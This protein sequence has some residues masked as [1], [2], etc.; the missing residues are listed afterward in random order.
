MSMGDVAAEIDAKFTNKSP[1]LGV[2]NSL[3]EAELKMP[4]LP[5]TDT[6]DMPLM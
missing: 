2:L 6:P 4:G 1:T 3:D 5:G